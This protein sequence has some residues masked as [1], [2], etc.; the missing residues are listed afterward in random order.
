MSSITVRK[1]FG[2]I[3]SAGLR[4]WP[5][6]LLTSTSSRPW[7]S[8]TPSNSA[9]TASSSRMSIATASAL[10]ASASVAA[11]VSSS[12]SSR[13]PQPTT[14]APSRASSSAVSRPS[15]LPAPE[16][17][18]TCPSSSPG[19]KIRELSERHGARR[20][21]GY[22]GPAMGVRA[23]TKPLR[24]PLPGGREGATVVVEPI[25]TGTMQC[26][27]AFI[28]SA[29]G[30]S[31]TLRMLGIGTPR[32]SWLTL[33]IPAYL[34]RHPDA[35]PVPGRHRPARLGRGEAGRE[36][37]P[38]RSRAS[39]ARRSSPARTCPAQLRDRGRRPEGDEARGD[40]PHALRPHLGDVGVPRR[41]L[42]DHRGGVD[43]GGDRLAPVPA[44]LPARALRLRVRLPHAQL[45]LR[46]DPLVRAPSAAP[47]TS[48]ATAASGSPRRPGTA[49]ATS[50]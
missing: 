43:R 31:P 41:H 38:A 11:A 21:Y 25:L 49:P 35:G 27:R 3:A 2:E 18:Q 28:E 19:A 40:D 50:R 6:A 7:R 5:P 37:R 16:T 26:P 9:S 1:P 12:G 13:R 22:S 23:E 15:P 34:I 46:R 29:G 33:P 44:R 32:S 17:T 45:R 10:P 14:V 20:L 48:S 24:A 39:R 4:N 42:R 30:A 36:P 47:S 8:S